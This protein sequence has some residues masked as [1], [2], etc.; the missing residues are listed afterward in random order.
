M[1]IEK[2]LKALRKAYMENAGAV[3]DARGRN[4]TESPIEELLISQMM[5]SGWDSSHAQRSW[6]DTFEDLHKL[7]GSCRTYKFLVSEDC[8]CIAVWQ[9]PITCG[10]K[11][12]R[13]DLAMVG[14]DIGGGTVKIAVELDGHDFHEKTKEQA[15]KDK[16]RDRDLVAAGWSV[17][18]FTGSEVYVGPDLVMNEI[19]ALANQRCGWD[20]SDYPSPDEGQ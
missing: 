2:K 15:R 17:L 3:F 1:S 10:P 4:W 16:S 20:L 7:I 5:V 12:Y 19:F 6:C 9:M 13:I 11:K 18:R 14:R 8:G